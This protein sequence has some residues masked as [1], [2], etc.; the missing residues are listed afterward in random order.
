M[1]RS[2]GEGS[3]GTARAARDAALCAVL[4]EAPQVVTETL[5][6]LA[7]RGVRVADVHLLCT[8][9]AERAARTRLL[10]RSGAL[11]RLAAVHALPRP[12]ARIVPLRSPAGRPLDDVRSTRDND[13]V[14]RQI[15]QAVAALARGRRPLV[16]SIAG[17]RK[18][19]GV[20]LTLAFELFARPGD[21]LF[22]VL[23][24]PEFERTDFFFP[25]PGE[26]DPIDLAEVAFP[27]LREY[28]PERADE[29]PSLRVIVDAVQR[30]IDAGDGVRL[31]FVTARGRVTAFVGDWELRCRAA[32]A[33]TW[34]AF[35]RRRVACGC[36]A[37]RQCRRC[38]VSPEQLTCDFGAWVDPDDAKGTAADLRAVCS[39]IRDAMRRAG[40]PASWTDRAGIASVGRRG[41]TRYG[42][43]LPADRIAIDVERSNP[44]AAARATAK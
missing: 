19:L 29:G 20:Y 35:A 28:L 38:F 33:V 21:R 31:R 18:T 16:G 8:R 36:A 5:Y 4:G 24:P 2:A 42:V 40:V 10:G 12:R 17:G 37:P 39:R 34:L 44:C 22:H 27:R 23:V 11:S 30:R 1:A 6:S 13:A 15:V 9:H 7:R 26:P 41:T 14:A 3:A 43:P 25:A 32:D